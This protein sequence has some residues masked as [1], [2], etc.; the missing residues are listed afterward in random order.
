MELQSFSSIFELFAT[1]TLAYVLVD[2]FTPEPFVSV[3]A[4]KI[5]RMYDPVHQKFKDIRTNINGARNDLATLVQSKKDLKDLAKADFEPLVRASEQLLDSTEYRANQ[6]LKE[7]VADIKNR[8]RTKRFAYL[9]FYLLLFCLFILFMSG[10]YARTISAV[11]DEQSKYIATLDL[12][13]ALFLAGTILYLVIA[14]L[15]DSRRKNG[16]SENI[17]KG[18]L[19]SLVVWLILIALS[20]SEFFTGLFTELFYNS[21]TRH[22][23]LVAICVFLPVSNFLVYMCKAYLRAKKDLPYF[24]NRAK[25][26]Y[27]DYKFEIA[28]VNKFCAA[29]GFNKED[30]LLTQK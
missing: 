14:W 6:S 17:K 8:L 13:L 12:C 10:F 27:D 28:K 29:Y 19:T 5:L 7:I 26:F 2:E 20:V 23:C 24:E 9:N 21:F 18:Y 25:Q 30:L 11:P 16:D 22:D 4:D 1:F 3:I 15:R